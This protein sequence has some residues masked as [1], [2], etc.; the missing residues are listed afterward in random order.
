MERRGVERLF[1]G[2]GKLGGQK[3]KKAQLCNSSNDIKGKLQCR[4]A[5]KKPQGGGGS[6]CSVMSYEGK[7]Q[8]SQLGWKKTI[9]HQSLLIV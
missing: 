6:A 4:E 5:K 2:G 9:Y 3:C 8:R 7:E 1:D